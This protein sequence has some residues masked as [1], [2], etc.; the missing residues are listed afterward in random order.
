[1]DRATRRDIKHDKFVEEMEIAYGVAR[2]NAGRLVAAIVAVI[3]IA[4]AV[5]GFIFWQHKRE[6][7]AQVQLAEAIRKYETAVGQPGP[8][9]KVIYAT[10]EQKLKET[11]PLFAA[12]ASKYS[13]RDAADVANLYLAQILAAKGDLKNAETK[14]DEFVKEHPD[15]LLGAAARIGLYNARIATGAAGAKDAIKSLENELNDQK[16]PLPV[17]TVLA[18]LARAYE[19]SGDPAKARDAYQRIVNEFPD[20]PYTLEAQRKIFRG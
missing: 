7:E 19:T 11:E 14:L 3:V 4:G 12:I 15:H 8:G 16:N 1:M 20:S 10:E 9:G 6:A 13:G 2:K 17:D 5:W 18:L